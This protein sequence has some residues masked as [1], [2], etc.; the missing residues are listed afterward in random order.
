MNRILVFT[1]VLVLLLSAC[2][3]PTAE[4]VEVKDAWTRPA[5]RGGNG[6]VYFTIRSSAAEE[7]VG[8]SSDVAEAVE[9]HE[10]KMS[11]DV[12]EMRQVQAV[13]LGAGEEMIFEPGG[14]HVMLVNLR[15]DLN[16]GDEIDITLH[17]KNYHDIPLRVPVQDTPASDH[18]H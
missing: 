6:A 3:A 17:F 12:M 1:L 5:T 2:A 11:G 13:P 7:L 4:N 18:N 16:A 10:S 15:Q 8:V 14:L 9:M